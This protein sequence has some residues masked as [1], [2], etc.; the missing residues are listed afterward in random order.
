MEMIF[1]MHLDFDPFSL[2]L[3]IPNEC[4]ASSANKKLYN[5][6][7]F[8]AKNILLNWIS[9][10]S[11]SLKGWHN[12]MFELIPLERLTHLCIT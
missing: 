10:K 9:D 8:N 11:P 1:N 2:L 4:F 3:G 7:S 6:L 12:I 5:I